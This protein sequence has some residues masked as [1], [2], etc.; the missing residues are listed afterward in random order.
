MHVHNESQNWLAPIARWAVWD[1]AAQQN[2]APTVAELGFI[3]PMLR[4]RLS[5]L[6][7]MSL[8][9]AHDCTHDLPAVHF[10]YASRHDELNRTSAML[11]ELASGESLSPTAFSLSVLN[12]SAG[13]FSILRHDKTPASA[14]SAATESF[15]YGLLEASSTPERRTPATGAACLCRRASAQHLW[16]NRTG[17]QQRPRHRYFAAKRRTGAHYLQHDTR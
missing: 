14:I 2:S 16:T 13:L 15:G 3:E 8:K 4:R 10:I 11:D 5:P 12:A 9:V 6:A 17:G 7:K 1:S